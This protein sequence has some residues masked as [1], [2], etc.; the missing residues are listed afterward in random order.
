M[1]E[2]RFVITA[3]LGRGTQARTLQ[4]IDKTNG[5]LIALKQFSVRGARQWKDV[6]L[7]EREALVLASLD[8]E[9]LPA[10]V[11]HFEED[12]CLYLAMEL[13]EGHTLAELQARG[14]VSQADVISF[15]RDVAGTLDYL[16]GRAPPIVHRD[17][18]PS[19]VIRR[20]D[21]RF[22]LVDF[23]SVSHKLE[24]DGGSTVVGTFGFMAPEQFQGRAMAASDVYSVGA[25]AITLLTGRDP[26]QLPHA[27]LGLDVPAALGA[28]VDPRLRSLLCRA[29]DPNPDARSGTSLRQLLTECGLDGD[30]AAADTAGRAKTRFDD[31]HGSSS[32]GTDGEPFERG[33]RTHGRNHDDHSHAAGASRSRTRGEWIGQPLIVMV[34][35]IGLLIARLSTSA[36][37]LVVLPLLLSMLSLLFGAGLRRA[38]HACRRAGLEA[39]R[40]LQRAT[41]MLLDTKR[42]SRKQRW[43]DPAASYPSAPPPPTPRTTKRPTRRWRAN[44]HHTPSGDVTDFERLIE[45]HLE[46]TARDLERRFGKRD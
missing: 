21:G 17:I 23:G 22:V 30:A 6:E 33:S 13:V 39:Q 11:T 14:Q 8:H 5:R 24:P 26:E 45:E 35:M 20:A 29:L 27:G 15:L 32:A 46:R 40:T 18:K 3:V 1:G 9:R 38:A 25:T 43:N 19:N 10:Y 37:L 44:A 4:A 41:R 12:G 2:G 28:G 31:R 7:A 16:H 42:Q 36:L 34:A